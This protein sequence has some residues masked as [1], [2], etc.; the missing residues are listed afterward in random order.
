[1]FQIPITSK[2][3]TFMV[4]CCQLVPHASSSFLYCM[5]RDFALML[6][7]MPATRRQCILFSRIGEHFPTF[8]NVVVFFRS[9]AASFTCLRNLLCIHGVLTIFTLLCIAICFVVTTI[10]SISSTHNIYHPKLSSITL[11]TLALIT[12]L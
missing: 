1:M 6:P 2:S 11:Q 10:T 12:G 7:L 5:N 9:I 3:N 4:K 8:C